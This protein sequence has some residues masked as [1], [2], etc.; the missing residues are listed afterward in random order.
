MALP[1]TRLPR[2]TARIGWN[3]RTQVVTLPLGFRFPPTVREVF[4]RHEGESVVLTPRPTDWSSFF[5][6][7]LRASP[8]F[9]MGVERLPVQDR[10]F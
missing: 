10:S 8:D 3:N 2:T 1:P 9:M 5:A 6:S 7:G 4:I